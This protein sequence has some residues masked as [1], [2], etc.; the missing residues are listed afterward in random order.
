MPRERR[1]PGGLLPDNSYG[2][3]VEGSIGVS[4]IAAAHKR[5]PAW[6]NEAEPVEGGA[7]PKKVRK[8]SL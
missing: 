6:E 2:G 1:A 3:G 5:A 7:R 8:N 4:S